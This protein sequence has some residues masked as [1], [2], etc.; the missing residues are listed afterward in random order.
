M[1]F[2]FLPN[3]SRMIDSF[4]IV[5]TSTIVPWNKPKNCRIIC[6]TV[7][8]SG[9]PGAGGGGIFG[10]VGATGGRGGGSGAMTR[11]AWLAN[12]LPDTIY[13][14]VGS[15]KATSTIAKQTFVSA[16]SGSQTNGG[17]V[18]RSGTSGG[19]ASGNIGEVAV[20]FPECAFFGTALSFRSIGGVN[21]AA[22]GVVTGSIGGTQ[23]MGLHGVPILG[24][25][26][27]AGV[28]VGGPDFAGGGVLASGPMQAIA[29]GLAGGGAGVNGI[30]L[31][32]PLYPF[33]ATGGTGGG[34]NFVAT[35]GRGGD[36]VFGG[37]G[38]GG[39]GGDSLFPLSKGGSGGDG[40]IFI[41]CF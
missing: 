27:G 25:C 8:G 24:G 35:G 37:G 23:S 19:E 21:G 2:G 14:S 39:G 10:G 31:R 29:G 15:G 4:S 11:C 6:I 26:G 3:T 16:T 41:A 9:A 34:S 7:I 18:I 12:D 30:V 32:P 20:T 36:G 17:L 40:A 38:G 13:I 33:V 28:D 5:T 1:D 22:G